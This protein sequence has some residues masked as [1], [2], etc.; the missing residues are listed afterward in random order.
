MTYLRYVA[1]RGL[2]AVVAAYLVVVATFLLGTMTIRDQIAN[3]LAAVGYRGTGMSG[4]RAG[5]YAAY[6]LNE[7][8]VDRLVGWLVDVTTLD[9]GDSMYYDEPVMAVLD[10]R[11]ATTLEYVI[12]GVLLAVLLGALLGL[13]TALARESRFDWGVRLGGYVL[14]AIPVFVLLT[15]MQTAA[16]QVVGIGGWQVALPAP[17]KQTLAALGVGLSLLAGQIRFARA[18]AL[19]QTGRSFVKMLHAKGIGRLRLA[20]HV[21][22]NA[23]IPIVS[24]SIADLLAVLV[25][26][27][28][29]IEEVL[30][31]EGLAGASLRAAIKSDIPLLMWSTMV[32]VVLGITASFLQDALHGYL[33]PRIGTD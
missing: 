4:L 9:A 18:A 3:R 26:N 12:P 27:I 24:I 8:L 10:G 22:R 20:R 30:R 1:R 19:E 28:Y 32:V 15:Y 2:F 11:I 21:L 29:V 14:L 5:L 7:P 13:A 16:G 17:G 6:D 31:I 33:D 23:A 25:L